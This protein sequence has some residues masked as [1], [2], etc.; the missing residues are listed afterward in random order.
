MAPSWYERTEKQNSPHPKC[1]KDRRRREQKPNLRQQ[2]K[3]KCKLGFSGGNISEAPAMKFSA[4][5][6]LSGKSS[7]A[8]VKGEIKMGSHR[9]T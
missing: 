6:L 9:T 5:N 3:G 8:S 1:Y 2:N 7:Q 4:K